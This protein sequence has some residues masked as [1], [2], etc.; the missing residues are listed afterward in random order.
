MRKSKWVVCELAALLVGTG[1][2]LTTAHAQQSTGATADSSGST[3]EEVVV[4][5]RRREEGV[6]HVP[7]SITANIPVRPADAQ[8]AQGNRP[9][10]PRARGASAT[11][12]SPRILI[13]A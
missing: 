2:G 13:M 1:C 6:E 12:S 7:E 8:T 9:T 4:T 10:D 11:A 5:A 3:L